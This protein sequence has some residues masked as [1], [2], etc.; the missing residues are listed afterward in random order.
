MTPGADAYCCF[1]VIW[2]LP[3]HLFQILKRKKTI[4]Y[5]YMQLS[6]RICM[7]VYTYV[8]RYAQIKCVSSPF[9]LMQI[10]WCVLQLCYET[11]FF[12]KQAISSRSG[13]TFKWR[14]N[15][16]VTGS[17]LS[18]AFRGFK[19]SGLPDFSCYNIPKREK[20]YQIPTKFTKWLLN[21]P[22]GRKLY[23]HHPLQDTPKI[24]PSWIFCLKKCHLAILDQTCSRLGAAAA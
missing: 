18:L 6:T 13:T 9:I 23:Q 21:R 24:Y 22:N 11:V 5:V 15:C 3:R 17:S 8:L 12:W 16:W 2:K 7:Y 10:L 14:K 19:L 1:K 4:Y 20:I